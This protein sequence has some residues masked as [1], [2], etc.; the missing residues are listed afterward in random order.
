[1]LI[2]SPHE[3]A[4]LIKSQ[5]KKLKLSQAEVAE[6]VGLKQKTISA[7]ENNPENIRLS[8]LFRILSALGLDFNAAPKN[9]PITNQWND[10]W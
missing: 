2:H 10:E 7:I 3:L 1:M 9:E 5:R 6:L 4:L 8:T